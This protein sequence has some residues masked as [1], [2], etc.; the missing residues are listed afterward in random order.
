PP[1][2]RPGGEP[3]R[4]SRDSRPPGTAGSARRARRGGEPADRGGG[5]GGALPPRRHGRGLDL[6]ERLLRAAAL[7]PGLRPGRP[8]PP[9]GRPL[10]CLGRLPGGAPAPAHLSPPGRVRLRR[11]LALGGAAGRGGGTA[12]PRAAGPGRSP[13][14]GPLRF[15]LYFP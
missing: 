14:G 12:C 4:R 3:C 6:P 9:G 10:P 8:P 5:G 15:H 2:S 11:R 1:P 7:P 13:P